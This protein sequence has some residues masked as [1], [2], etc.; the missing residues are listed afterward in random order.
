[1]QC[2]VNSKVALAVPTRR[3]TMSSRG[4]IRLAANA[5]T[6]AVIERSAARY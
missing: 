4:Q 3:G 6:H 1:M 2:V 5:M